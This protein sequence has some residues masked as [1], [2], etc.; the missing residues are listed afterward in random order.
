M[1]LRVLNL[2]DSPDDSW[3]LQRHLDRDGYEC[4]LRREETCEDFEKALT[5][6]EWDVILADYFLPTFTA[7]DALRITQ[8]LGSD[9]PFIVVSGAVGE[10]AAV[11][12]LREG[13]ADYVT[14]DSLARLGPAINREIQKADER[15]GRRAAEAALRKSE[16]RLR[17]LLDNSPNAV[18][19]KDG[20]DKYV[21]VNR[22]YEQQLGL[23]ET[24]ICGKSDAQ[25][26]AQNYASVYTGNDVT[27]REAGAPM[28]FEEHVPFHDGEHIWLANRFPLY[29][30]SGNAEGICAI[31]TDIT[32]LKQSEAALRRSEKL[33]AAGR[34]AAS[35]AHEINNPLEALT[36]LVFLVQQ[37]PELLQS[38]RE[39]LALAE[40]ELNRVSHIT[41]QALAFYR[42]SSTPAVVDLGEM[43][44]SLV[45]LFDNRIRQRELHIE[46]RGAG[47]C[48]VRTVHGEMRQVFSNLIANAIDASHSR[49]RILIRVHASRDWSRPGLQGMRVTVADNGCGIPPENLR[50]IFD[51]FF[52]TKLDGTGT[53]LGLWVTHNILTK[54]NAT[55]RMR[56]SVTQGSSGTITSVFIPGSLD[57]A[58]IQAQ[59]ESRPFEAVPQ[60]P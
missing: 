48:R 11:E 49:G 53:G 38:T 39:M 37:Q 57:L 27:V 36:N 59:T 1:R 31:C 30:E 20:S 19:M 25:L 46:V 26:F 40:D 54:H 3:L 29:G 14:K 41:R 6:G 15:R 10:Q 24:E 44:N 35:I 4:V 60:L 52:T 47:D 50:R 12:V 55:I 28:Q 9:V 18:F 21:L 8:R 13:A 32:D 22:C 51:A 56:S 5:E 58:P 23:T 45:S 2:E 33:A 43:I 34:L 16:I 17:A 7:V 42:D